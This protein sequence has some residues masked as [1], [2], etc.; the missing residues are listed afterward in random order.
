MCEI[1]CA[2]WSTCLVGLVAQLFSKRINSFA[3]KA[4]GEILKLQNKSLLSLL[5]HPVVKDCEKLS[6]HWL[7]RMNHSWNFSAL[8]WGPPIGQNFAV[9]SSLSKLISVAKPMGLSLFLLMLTS[10]LNLGSVERLWDQW[11]CLISVRSAFCLK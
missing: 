10:N 9:S 3:G 7:Q 6:Q 4:L 5:F 11:E 1:I 8:C 2:S